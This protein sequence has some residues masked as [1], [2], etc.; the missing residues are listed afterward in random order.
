MN[1]NLSDGNPRHRVR[2]KLWFGLGGALLGLGLVYSA[3]WLIIANRDMNYLN[4]WAEGQRQSGYAVRWDS[5]KISGYPFRIIATLDQPR[6]DGSVHDATQRWAWTVDAVTLSGKPWS[7]NTL[8]LNA[9]GHHTLTISGAVMETAQTITLD[10]GSLSIGAEFL[11]GRWRHVTA[12][13]SD[14]RIEQDG[15]LVSE[16]ARVSSVLNREYVPPAPDV[17]E[18]TRTG[19]LHI[20]LNDLTIPALGDQLVRVVG[21]IVQYAS[22][23]VEVYGSLPVD[24]SP[25][26]LVL[27][28]DAGG[29]VEVRQVRADYGPLSLDAE[30]ALA[31]DG[32]LQP[33]GSF[34]ARVQGFSEAI[35]ALY[36]V[37][38]ITDG[39]VLTAK[40]VLGALAK[41]DAITGKSHL[42][43]P[44]NIQDRTIF[45]GPLTLAK[46]PPIRW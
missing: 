35:D 2:W 37:G 14:L 13:G 40:L 25:S 33:V 5:A 10:A 8:L 20:S 17:D 44:V 45:A 1:M 18:R 29:V 27:W 12:S 15:Q 9:P 24:L 46:L 28:R 6:V 42:S 16:L 34:V 3:F 23:N 36:G 22:L 26:S 41:K 19:A 38:M 32:R 21:S 4:L 39:D 11:G 30:G 7:W 31:L 43:I